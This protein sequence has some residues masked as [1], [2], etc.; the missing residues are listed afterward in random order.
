MNDLVLSVGQVRKLRNGTEACPDVTHDTPVAIT[1]GKLIPVSL[2]Q[3]FNSFQWLLTTYLPVKCLI[4]DR[5]TPL[6]AEAVCEGQGQHEG[7]LV[8][9]TLTVRR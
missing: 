4:G 1:Q 5:M 7:T 2:Q 8:P 3:L 9:Q 6:Q